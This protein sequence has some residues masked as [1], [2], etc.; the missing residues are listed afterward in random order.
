MRASL[1]LLARG[2][3]DRILQSKHQAA[4]PSCSPKRTTTSTWRRTRCGSG[5]GGGGGA[6]GTRRAA[7]GRRRRRRAGDEGLGDGRAS[8]AAA[9]GDSGGCRRVSRRRPFQSRVSPRGLRRGLPGVD[10]S[11][12]IV[13]PSVKLFRVTGRVSAAVSVV[14]ASSSLRSRCRSRDSGRSGRPGGDGRSKWMRA[15]R[16]RDWP[17]R[18]PAPAS[19]RRCGRSSRASPRGS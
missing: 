2:V 1:A 19:R 18:R 11:I 9:F 8:A 13:L 16:R 17:D 5:S 15:S 7:G 12:A 14:P 10:E 4:K 3:V 6:R